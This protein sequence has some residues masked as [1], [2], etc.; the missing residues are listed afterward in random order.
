MSSLNNPNLRN[1]LHSEQ[2][3]SMNA[4]FDS[5]NKT[6]KHKEEQNDEVNNSIDSNIMNFYDDTSEV[7]FS[8]SKTFKDNDKEASAK[9][10]KKEEVKQRK[11]NFFDLEIQSEDEKLMLNKGPSKPNTSIDFDFH[12]QLID[13]NQSKNQLLRDILKQQNNYNNH[14]NDN[15]LK[16]SNQ[17]IIL[18]TEN[19]AY[20]DQEGGLYTQQDKNKIKKK[21]ENLE[22]TADKKIS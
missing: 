7:S 12:N 10:S 9:L 22:F 16:N 13:A 20:F 18:D 14:N 11:T 8:S 6:N 19:Q 5:A 3:V 15:Y 2:E 21:L 1:K 17:N 4:S